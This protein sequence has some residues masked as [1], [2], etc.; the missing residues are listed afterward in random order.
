MIT[1]ATPLTPILLPLVDTHAHINLDPFDSDLEDLIAR[2]RA[3]QFPEM[4]GR[5]IGADPVAQPFVSGLICPA[6]DLE[7]SLRALAIA[8][9][10]PFVFAAAGAHPNHIS[11]LKPGEWD[12]ICQLIEKETRPGS[13]SG[14]LVALGETGLDRYWDKSPFELQQKYFLQTLEQGRRTKLP[15][16]I[17]SRDANDDLDRILCDFYSDERPDWNV[18]VVHSFSGT[19]EQAERWLEL[20]FYLGFGG[21]VTYKSRSVSDIWEAAR[22]A[23]A[24][25]ILLETDCPFLTP[26]PARGKIDR[27]EPI[28]TTFVAKRLAELRGVSAREV[29]LQTA[30]NA[31]A[32]FKLPPLPELPEEVKEESRSASKARS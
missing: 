12:E 22:L 29:A 6:V 4:K 32:L 31:A 28:L 21:L 27:N 9:K 15:V 2:S 3:G 24:D 1:N 19:P 16:I 23:P 10:H 26:H 25:R 8:K 5:Q 7:T 18:G 30:K 13:A 11:L 14:K 17:H 20:G